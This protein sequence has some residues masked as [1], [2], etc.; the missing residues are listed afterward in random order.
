MVFKVILDHKALYILSSYMNIL[1]FLG[2]SVV[3]NLPALGR[4]P[5]E[6]SGNPLKY[7]CLRNSMDRGGW[8][9]TFH[10]VAKELDT[11]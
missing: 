4:S 9:A 8:W 11:T 2:G 1:D 7:F 10:G 6:E 3:E 5:A